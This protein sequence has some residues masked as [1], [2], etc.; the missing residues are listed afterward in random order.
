MKDLA[1][2]F[3][4][5]PSFMITALNR[6]HSRHGRQVFF[7]LLTRPPASDDFIST[8]YIEECKISEEMERHSEV[9]QIIRSYIKLE[10]RARTTVCAMD[11]NIL[12]QQEL[13][14]RVAYYRKR[15]GIWQLARGTF[16]TP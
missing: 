3:D 13:A 2:A 1:D 5:L 11:G 7:D 12:A 9:D 16:Q 6:C 10:E 15:A 14:Q 4:P 8:F